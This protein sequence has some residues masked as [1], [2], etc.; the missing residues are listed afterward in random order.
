MGLPRGLQ[1][2][3]LPLHCMIKP[4]I[5]VSR[6]YQNQPL[7]TPYEDQ[8]TFC[9]REL[10]SDSLDVSF[11]VIPLVER[12]ASRSSLPG[13]V[14]VSRSTDTGVPT[15]GTASVTSTATKA[16]TIVEAT[17]VLKTTGGTKATTSSLV[18]LRAPPGAV[19][20]LGADGARNARPV[21]PHVLARYMESKSHIHAY[22]SAWGTPWRS[23]RP[24]HSCGKLRWKG[25]GACR[26]P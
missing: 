15:I 24:R 11:T 26:T 3:R 21:Y 17:S 13:A 16:S 7:T 6:R 8:A 18:G 1:W 23:D 19:A 2:K 12:K 10:M 4:A 9:R 25:R 14:G 20:L 5:S 22:P